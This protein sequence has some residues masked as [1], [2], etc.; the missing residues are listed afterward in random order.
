[1]LFCQVFK[2]SLKSR[3]YPVLFRSLSEGIALN[4]D[5]LSAVSWYLPRA[6]CVS[7]GPSRF[8]AS[9]TLCSPDTFLRYVLD[10]YYRYDST[11]DRF[12]MTRQTF[13]EKLSF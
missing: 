13:I 8:S 1:M 5:V 9:S 11:S 7:S 12:D 4:D 6:K 2:F 3:F 10:V